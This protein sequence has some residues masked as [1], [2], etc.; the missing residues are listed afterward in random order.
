MK[1]I[2]LSIEVDTSKLPQGCEVIRTD[3]GWQLEW[4]TH[5][6]DRDQLSL[7]DQLSKALKLST[8][9]IPPEKI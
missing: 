3:K 1:T 4:P 8:L 7:I 6:P 2:I 9:T 5:N